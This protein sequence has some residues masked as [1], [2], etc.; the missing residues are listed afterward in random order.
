MHLI[1][2]DMQRSQDCSL[3]RAW[4]I[5]RLRRYQANPQNN[6]VS[7]WEW[8]RFSAGRTT[9][10]QTPPAALPIVHFEWSPDTGEATAHGCAP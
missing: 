7:K 2:F 5:E 9:M 10:R 3:A 1:A 8:T 4:S 6:T